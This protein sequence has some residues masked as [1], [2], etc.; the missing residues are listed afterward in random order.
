MTR[1]LD[2]FALIK[3]AQN[4]DFQFYDKLSDQQ[5]KEF[6][7]VVVQRWISGCDDPLQVMMVNEYVNPY[8]FALH[9]H[10]QLLYK[11]MA[12]ASQKNNRCTYPKIVKNKDKSTPLAVDVIKRML[13]VSTDE[14]TSLVKTMKPQDIIDAGYDLGYDSSDIKKLTKELM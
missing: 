6:A 7:P 11:L 2:V 13:S 10:P 3:A 8:V 1:S 9:K 5:R 4:K 14:A 12:V